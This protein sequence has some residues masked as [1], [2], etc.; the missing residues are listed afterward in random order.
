MCEERTFLAMAKT[1][2]QIEELRELIDKSSAIVAVTG[3][4]ISFSTGGLSFSDTG[5]GDFNRMMAIGSED[6]LRNDPDLY[7]DALDEYF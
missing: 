5:R 6:V 4:G 7:Y 2:A 1:D 3:A